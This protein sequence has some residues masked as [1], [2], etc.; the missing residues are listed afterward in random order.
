MAAALAMEVENGADISPGVEVV[1]VFIAMVTDVSARHSTIEI[2]RRMRSTH[3]R[4]KNM[5]RPVDVP[6]TVR[7]AM[8]LGERKFT[9]TSVRVSEHHVIFIPPLGDD[10]APFPL[11]HFFVYSFGSSRE[12][13]GNL[14][15]LSETFCPFQIVEV[16]LPYF[17]LLYPAL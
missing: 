16:P 5:S 12:L 7:P 2:S 8:G 17:F 4:M 1:N 15:K 11:L 13:P 14:W 10:V 6:G 9:G 3:R